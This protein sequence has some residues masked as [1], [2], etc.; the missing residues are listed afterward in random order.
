MFADFCFTED[1]NFDGTVV[2]RKQ[3]G[4]IGVRRIPVETSFSRR[5]MMLQGS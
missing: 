2:L 3:R 5:S 4:F 1:L